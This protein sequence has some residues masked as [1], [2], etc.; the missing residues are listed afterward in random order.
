MI[1]ATNGMCFMGITQSY[2]IA[3]SVDATIGFY[4]GGNEARSKQSLSFSWRTQFVTAVLAGPK[5]AR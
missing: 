1:V 5:R 4:I 3:A 2:Y